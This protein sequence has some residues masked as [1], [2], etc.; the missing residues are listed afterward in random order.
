VFDVDGRRRH[1][2]YI[3]RKK[4]QTVK[5]VSCAAQSLYDESEF[6]PTIRTHTTMN[7]KKIIANAMEL[8][9]GRT[10]INLT[11]DAPAAMFHY[12]NVKKL[13]EALHLLTNFESQLMSDL[14]DID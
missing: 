14:T 7:A 10:R 5:F 3:D 12:E 6:T 1:Y 9:I 4:K 13:S 8:E 11:R 2:H